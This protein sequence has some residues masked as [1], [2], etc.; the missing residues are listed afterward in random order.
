M[1]RL[2]QSFIDKHTAGGTANTM[3]TLVCLSVLACVLK[4]FFEGV[5]LHIFGHPVQLGHADAMSYGAI[6]SPILGAHAARGW[7]GGGSSDASNP[8]IENPDAS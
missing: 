3:H 1:T 8:N 4:F 6:L 2:L 5:T 7:S